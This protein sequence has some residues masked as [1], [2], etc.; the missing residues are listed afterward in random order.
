MESSTSGG[1][2]C[3]TFF[4]DL[5]EQ[6]KSL[7]KSLSHVS[8]SGD[9]LKSSCEAK[10]TEI[11]AWVSEQKKKSKEKSKK[12]PIENVGKALQASISD[13]KKFKTG[14][15]K[16]EVAEG[17]LEIVASMSE[18]T[19]EPHGPPLKAVCVIVSA[20]LAYKRP[21]Q[22]SVVDRLAKV[23]HE[24]LVN[25]NTKLQD[26]K[27]NGL[28]RRLSDQVTQLCT[29]RSG[30]RLDDPNLWSDF[31]QFLGELSNRFEAPLPFQYDKGS[32]TK[33][34]DLADFVTAV[35][36]YC[37]AY[38]CFMALLMVAK[39]TFEA[40]GQEYKDDQDAVNRRISCQQNDVRE[41]LSFFSDARYLTFLGRMPYE[42]GKLTKIVALS[43]NIEGKGLVETVRRSL[44]LPPMSDSATVESAAAKVAGQS[45]KLRLQ[46]HHVPPGYGF[47]WMKEYVLGP[48]FWVQYINETDFPMKIV[49]RE[50]GGSGE[51]SFTYDVQPHS[52]R[53]V[54]FHHWSF[55]RLGLYS[56]GYIIIFLNGKARK[57][58]KPRPGD[59]RVLEFAFCC[60][61]FSS[62]IN[63]QDNT[64]N[65]FTQGENAYNAMKCGEVK[66]LYWFDRGMHFMAR[67]E[68]IQLPWSKE[69]WRFLIQNFDPL[70]IQD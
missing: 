12:I 41:K 48:P 67:A 70:S 44:N 6:I 11:N 3:A 54:P 49:S 58:L 32:L 27:Y 51:L 28:K 66:T 37:E 5:E 34:P 50:K 43:R 46:G 19:G 61:Y 68:D 33:D 30:E 16:L 17:I 4:S 31:I 13:M 23:V 7:R 55:W 29:M 22:A 40:L 14:S 42:G 26:H 62:M 53:P 1:E 63:I 9:P 52:C 21:E 8:A 15:G 60:S 59:T 10:L 64:G 56:R 45:V 35:V 65:E 25:F 24:Q 57:D 38:N 36:T 69:L 2:K 47:R 18:L 39:G 20:V